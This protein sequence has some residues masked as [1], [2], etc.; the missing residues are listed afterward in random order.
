MSANLFKRVHH[1][2]ARHTVA[3]AVEADLHKTG[4][5][6]RSMLDSIVATDP[7]SDVNTF[8]KAGALVQL[9]E[10]LPNGEDL[11]GDARWHRADD[12]V[13]DDIDS[14]PANELAKKMTGRR[15]QGKLKG[16]SDNNA[17]PDQTQGK[18]RPTRRGSKD[19]A[20]AAADDRRE[21]KTARAECRDEASD[22]APRRLA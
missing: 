19:V 5:L 10:S 22:P 16:V 15:G 14:L 4:Q 1:R 6:D 2:T 3:R 7:E 21:R 12:D 17:V 11:V 20:A 18:P 8:I 13:G 9:G